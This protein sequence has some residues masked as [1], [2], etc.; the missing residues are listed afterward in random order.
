VVAPAPR[1]GIGSKDPGAPESELKNVFQPFAGARDRRSGRTG[2]GLVIA[3]R[4]GEGPG[5]PWVND[6]AA[7]GNSF[8]RWNGSV[9]NPH[10]IQVAGRIEF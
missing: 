6:V 2:L 7:P 10:N 4:E 9:G 1:S 3:E 5:L 8:G